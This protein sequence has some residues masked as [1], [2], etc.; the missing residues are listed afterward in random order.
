[1]ADEQIKGKLLMLTRP[2]IYPFQENMVQIISQDASLKL[3]TRTGESFPAS[4]LALPRS[5]PIFEYPGNV[6]V[7]GSRWTS[8]SCGFRSFDR[9]Y[10]LGGVGFFREDFDPMRQLRQVWIRSSTWTGRT[11]LPGLVA[12]WNWEGTA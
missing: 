6:L 12:I 5:A 9:I 3:N 4:D 7:A 11:S 2:R 10:E 8:F 1:M